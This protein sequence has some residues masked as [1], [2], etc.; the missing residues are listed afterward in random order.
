MN[1]HINLGKNFDFASSQLCFEN[2]HSPKSI[3]FTTDSNIKNIYI[4]IYFHRCS[5]FTFLPQNWGQS[6]QRRLPLHL[7]SCQPVLRGA[8]ASYT[9]SVQQRSMYQLFVTE[10][11]HLHHAG[12]CASRIWLSSSLILFWK[13]V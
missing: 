4:Y 3:L 8:I 12:Q 13:I 6:L 9:I 11:L 5:F 7:V 1:R 10:A 2:D